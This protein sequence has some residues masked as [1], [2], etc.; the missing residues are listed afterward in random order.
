MLIVRY[1]GASEF[2][3]VP[4]AYSVRTVFYRD[5]DLYRTVFSLICFISNEIS[6]T[7]VRQIWH[8]YLFIFNALRDGTNLQQLSIHRTNI[9][10]HREPYRTK[11]G[12]A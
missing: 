9:E 1:N 11:I 2:V 12:K 6:Q 8:H 4:L 10:P 5:R 7:V 3:T